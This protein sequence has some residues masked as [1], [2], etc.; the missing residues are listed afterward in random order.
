[1]ELRDSCGCRRQTAD[2]LRWSTGKEPRHG[3]KYVEYKS[4]TNPAS[5]SPS[6]AD[7]AKSYGRRVLTVILRWMLSGEETRR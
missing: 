7:R 3:K 6:F 2:L 5:T 4:P 1:M